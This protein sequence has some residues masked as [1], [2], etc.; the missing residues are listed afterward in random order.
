MLR[1][2][3][4]AVPFGSGRPV[5]G[6]DLVIGDGEAVGMVGP[7]GSGSRRSSTR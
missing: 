1:G 4:I 5:E 6:I 3:E 2:E 7:N